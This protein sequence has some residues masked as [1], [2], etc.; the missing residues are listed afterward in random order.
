MRLSNFLYQ[1]FDAP[2]VNYH[3]LSDFKQY[4]FMIKFLEVRSPI[5]VSL[6]LRV[7]LC[8]FWRL[9]GGSVSCLFQLLEIAY[10]PW[11]LGC[12]LL[13]PSSLWFSAAAES[14]ALLRTHE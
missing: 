11:V 12:A 4:Q 13:M 10:I 5:G 1:F 3:R 8:P 9:W 14:Y 2:V 6:G 7:G